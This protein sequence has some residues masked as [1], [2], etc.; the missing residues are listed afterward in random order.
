MTN[1]QQ[2]GSTHPTGMHSCY[3]VFLLFGSSFMNNTLAGGSLAD[4][5]MTFKE[6]QMKNIP[7]CL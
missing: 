5:G 3:V 2:A 6:N 1:G 7:N 4:A